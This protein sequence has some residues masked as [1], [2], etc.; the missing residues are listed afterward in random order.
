M[1]PESEG[2]VSGLSPLAYAPGEVWQ[3]CQSARVKPPSSSAVPPGIG[4]TPGGPRRWPPEAS[5]P[6]VSGSHPRKP[7]QRHP[8]QHSAA[9]GSEVDLNPAPGPSVTALAACRGQH[10]HWAH[11]PSPRCSPPHAWCPADNF[12]ARRAPAPPLAAHCAG[13]P[14]ARTRPT[15]GEAGTAPRTEG[16][17]GHQWTRTPH[18][19]RRTASLAHPGQLAHLPPGPPQARRAPLP[20]HRPQEPPDSLHS[21]PRFRR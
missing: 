5:L 6:S 8:H 9:P 7:L 16:P 13:R 10:S 12:L 15:T 18:P 1:R 20:S 17:V 3:P 4:A 2:S 21:L 11:L 19:P 14:C